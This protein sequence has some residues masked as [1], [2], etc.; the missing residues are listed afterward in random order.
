M[1]ITAEHLS[2]ADI[3]SVKP[4]KVSSK[5]VEQLSGYG[6]VEIIRALDDNC[7]WYDATT[8]LWDEVFYPEGNTD[9]AA[10]LC[11]FVIAAE[12]DFQLEQ[13]RKGLL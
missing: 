11:L 5:L 13:M 4:G 10:E 12:W 1:R 9:L 6:I 3:T 8:D 7:G 2:K